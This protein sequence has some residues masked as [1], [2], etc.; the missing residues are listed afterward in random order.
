LFKGGCKN[1]PSNYR[2][3]SLLTTFSKILKII[4]SRRNQHVY[5]HYI[6]VIEQFSFRRQSST[7]ASYVLFNEILEALNKQK[8]VGGILSD[9]KKAFDSVDHDILSSKLQFY[10]IGGKFNCILFTR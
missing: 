6:I 3:I 4:L 1:D 9:L 7:K 10:G 8:I 2:P 5:D